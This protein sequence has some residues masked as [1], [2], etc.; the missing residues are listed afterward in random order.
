MYLLHRSRKRSSTDSGPEI[1]ASGGGDSTPSSFSTGSSSGSNPCSSAH[2]T[3]CAQSHISSSLPSPATSTAAATAPA[4]PAITWAS[5]H[6]FPRGNRRLNRRVEPVLL[7]L[8]WSA[9]GSSARSDA[10]LFFFF[11]SIELMGDKGISSLP[12]CLQPA[13]VFIICWRFYFFVP[14]EPGKV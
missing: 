6:R 3:N 12:N 5:I 11:N 13:A 1:P 8:V 9:T 14:L 10:A 2:K 7:P 4:T